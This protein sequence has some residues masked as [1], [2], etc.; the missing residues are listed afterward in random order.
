M[1]PQCFRREAARQRQRGGQPFVELVL[2]QG[3]YGIDIFI[4]QHAEHRQP[5]FGKRQRHQAAT[6][7][8][9]G[10]RIMAD[11]QYGERVAG[12][13]LKTAGVAHQQQPAFDRTDIHRQPCI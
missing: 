13:H 12:Q 4:G 1:L 3:N 7:S 9:G 6:Q 11:I 10:V 8:A 5:F 2:Q